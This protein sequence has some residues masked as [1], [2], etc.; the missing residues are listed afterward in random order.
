MNECN[1]QEMHD[2]AQSWVFAPGSDA[3]ITKASSPWVCTADRIMTL[4][5]QPLTLVE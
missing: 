3:T 4:R 1:G 2:I 5:R